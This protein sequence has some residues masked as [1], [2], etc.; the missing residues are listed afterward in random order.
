MPK[1]SFVLPT[2]NR[3][4]WMPECLQS[5]LEQTEKDIEIIV[6]N[7]AST[8]G[9]KEFLDEWAVKDQ[10]V[11]VI[12]ND[13]SMGGGVSR[14][15]GAE[16]STSEIIAVCD[17]DDV[18][19]NDRAEATLRWFSEHPE[20]EMV[21]FPY[22]RIGY[23]REILETF[24]GGEFDTDAFK[25]DGTV[26]YFCNPSAAY[27]KSAAHE[28]GGYCPEKEGMTDDIQFVKNWIAAGKK[29]DFD[30][31]IFGVMHRVLPES[32]MAKQR[33]FRPEW[34]GAR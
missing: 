12:H 20:S 32:M 14:N 19:P 24:W 7:D 15:I 17:D 34:V 5:L 23:F 25:K 1:L 21:N 27:K 30:K 2:H 6:V 10:R 18:Y 13:K 9:T 28:I 33:G 22:V 31:R 8:D 11:K 4:E 3:I 26:S 29:I 16:A